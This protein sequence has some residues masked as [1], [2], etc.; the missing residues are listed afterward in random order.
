[1][2]FIL[3]KKIEMTQVFD[4]SGE[5]TP[6]TL[7]EAGPCKVLQKKNKEKDLYEAVQIGYVEITKKN[8][9]KKPSTGKHFKYI[10]EFSGADYNPGDEINSSIFKV[11]DIVNVSGKSKGKG[12]QGGMKKWGFSGAGGSHGVKHTKRKIGS[13]GGAFPQRV[14]KGKKMPGRMGQERITVKGLKVIKVENNIITLKGAVPGRRGTL[15]EI[16]GK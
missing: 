13:I 14:L 8:Q 9:M 15:L 5:V 12:F 11:G 2:K 1:M 7:V 3:G 10:K 6:V 4:E 16:T